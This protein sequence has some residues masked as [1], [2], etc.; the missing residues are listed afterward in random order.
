MV[1]KKN[2]LEE[3]YGAIGQLNGELPP[4]SQLDSSAETVLFGA[5]S[6][7]DSLGL[8][9]LIV[10]TEQRLQDRFGVAVTIADERAMSQKNSPFRTVGT[11]ADYVEL[12]LGESSRE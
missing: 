3:I 11:L 8:V 9:N 2:I 12:L 7:L 5:G 10:G 6:K 1:D 4:D